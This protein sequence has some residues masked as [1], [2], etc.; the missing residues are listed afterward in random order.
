MTYFMLIF[1]CL[2]AVHSHPV[3]YDGWGSIGSFRQFSIGF[4]FKSNNNWG[5]TLSHRNAELSSSFTKKATHFRITHTSPQYV[6][7]NILL[8]TYIICFLCYFLFCNLD[9]CFV[10]IFCFFFLVFVGCFV[11][12]L[13]LACFLNICLIYQEQSKCLGQFLGKGKVKRHVQSSGQSLQEKLKSK[14]VQC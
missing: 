5:V 9:S 1:F 6:S 14:K 3:H 12:G 10:L 2:A 8:K 7:A 11:S 13:F 4:C